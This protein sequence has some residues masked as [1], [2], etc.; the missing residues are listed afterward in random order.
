MGHT[1][2]GKIPKSQKWAN[3]IQS[4]SG[5]ADYGGLTSASDA[6]EDIAS[7]T[8]DAAQDYLKTATNDLG[9]QYTF[10]LLA[11]IAIASRN[12]GWVDELRKFGIHL[13][14]GDSVL[15]FT[16]EFQN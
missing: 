14:D 4:L 16:T 9:L 13:T 10:Y 12:D 2:L 15:E 5:V 6:V 11:R 8:L 7:Q 1:R 3:V